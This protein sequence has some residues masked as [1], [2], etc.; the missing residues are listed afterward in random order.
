V[1]NA[2]GDPIFIDGTKIKGGGGGTGC[3]GSGNYMGYSYLVEHD[4]ADLMN[5]PFSAYIA[6]GQ[7]L[8]F[9]T[10]YFLWVGT[11]Y[12]W[13]MYADDIFLDTPLTLEPGVPF[14]V[15]IS[16]KWLNSDN[17]ECLSQTTTV[18]GVWDGCS[19]ISDGTVSLMSQYLG[20]CGDTAWRDGQGKFNFVWEAGADQSYVPP[21]AGNMSETRPAKKAGLIRK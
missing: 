7:L 8:G 19:Y 1:D 14:S 16:F 12:Y 17:K 13:P 18:G 3:V 9:P 2:S 10:F 5:A 15:E 4:Y 6:D 20:S 21:V 11:T